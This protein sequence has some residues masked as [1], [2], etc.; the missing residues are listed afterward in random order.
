MVSIE[1]RDVGLVYEVRRRLSLATPKPAK[2][3]EQKN[4]RIVGRKKLVTA[5]EGIS[6]RLD[7]GDRLGLI[8][9]NGAG[10]T[11]LLKILYGIYQPTSGYAKVEGRA[12]ALFNIG[13]GFRRDATGR[14]NIQLRGLINGWTSKQI[15]SKIDEI[16]EF[17][18]LGDFVDMPFKLYSQG[19]AARLAFSIATSFSTEILLMDEWIGAGDEKFQKKAQKRMRELSDSAGI[20]VL[21]S[22]NKSIIKNTCNKVF[23]LESKQLL[24]IEDWPLENA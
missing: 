22:H 20:V 1:L 16:V 5:L 11:T 12:D 13:L 17:S 24:N 10:K 19:M 14:R 18:E 7:A 3:P 2:N 9:P 6:F 8:G 4:V 15:D 21:A 23:S